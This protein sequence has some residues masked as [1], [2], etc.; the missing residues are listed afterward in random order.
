MY[1]YLRAET[2]RLLRKKSLF[3][4]LILVI[5]GYL[6]LAF[7]R[8]GGISDESIVSDTNLFMLL[9]PVIGGVLFAAIYTDDL[10]SKNL[11]TLVGFG[12]GKAKI[13]LVKFILMAI[14]AAV[15]F[16][17]TPVV[18]YLFYAFF[19]YVASPEI[20]GGIYLLAFKYYLMSL[21]FAVLSGILV[22]GVQRSTVA[23]VTFVVLSIGLVGQLLGLVVNNFLEDSSQYLPSSII[24]LLYVNLASQG[25]IVWPIFGLGIYIIGAIILSTV[26]F[27]KKEMEF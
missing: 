23:V 22:Y 1:N 20:M 6:M 4:F 18:M 19:G 24:D 11:S 3:V 7:A 12:L 9:P 5:A 10:S 14:L 17:L 16:G 15:I 25:P 2:Y 8:S 21:V 27:N 26:L 13:V